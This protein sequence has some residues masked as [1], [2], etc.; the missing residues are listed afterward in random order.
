MFQT[1]VHEK[2]LPF[3]DLVADCLYGHS[4]AFLEAVDMCV[5]VTGL[6]AIPSETRCWLQRPPTT[7]KGCRD[8]GE[9]RAQRVV[10][11]PG[12]LPSTVATVAGRLPASHWEGRKVSAGT[13]GP[14]ASALARQRVTLCQDGLADRPGW[15]G[16]KRTM[17]S[18][19]VYSYA[20]SHAPVSPPCALS[21]GSVVCAGPWPKASKKAKP[22]W[23]WTPMK[24][25]SMSGGTTIG[26]RRWGP[27]VFC[28]P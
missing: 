28:G 20:L 8:K 1:L 27:I 25:A 26:S 6:L 13:Q 12:S 10:G 3:Q 18:N 17:G 11:D 9:A 7:E 19:P 24:S 16:I 14:I 5:G 4:P 23:V 22:S 2:L 15:L 21:S